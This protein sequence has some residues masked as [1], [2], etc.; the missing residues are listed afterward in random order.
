MGPGVGKPRQG[1]AQ[2]QAAPPASNRPLLC[3]F[4]ICKMGPRHL[5]S[6]LQHENKGSVKVRQST[7]LPGPGP[8]WV[9]GKGAV[10][11]SDRCL[12]GRRRR[13]QK[14]LGPLGPGM[15]WAGVRWAGEAGQ[16]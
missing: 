14:L 3:Y 2:A 11:L 15:G 13:K 4:P 6:G 9:L 8:R 5:P 1:A 12:R 16:G 7:P 10:L